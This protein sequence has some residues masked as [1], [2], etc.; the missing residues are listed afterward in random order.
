LD[1]LCS[2]FCGDFPPEISAAVDPAPV[3][4]G[5]AKAAVDGITEADRLYGRTW[6]P[7]KARMAVTALGQAAEQ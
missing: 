6:H 1:A 7:A 4:S 2:C 5:D 3:D